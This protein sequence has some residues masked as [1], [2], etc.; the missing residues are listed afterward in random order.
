[1]HLH[2]FNLLNLVAKIE[3]KL[4]LQGL[5]ELAKATRSLISSSALINALEF[6]P[7]TLSPPPLIFFLRNAETHQSIHSS[8]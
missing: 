6:G 2:K 1:V 8:A 5:Q 3:F 7:G 4:L